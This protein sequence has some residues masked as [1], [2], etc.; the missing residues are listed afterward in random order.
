MGKRY[1]VC[2]VY[3]G[4]EYF[5]TFEPPVELTNETCKAVIADL[6]NDPIKEVLKSIPTKKEIYPHDI[7]VRDEKGDIINAFDNLDF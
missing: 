6:V 5:A 2:F 3:D 7:V 1:Q 4:K